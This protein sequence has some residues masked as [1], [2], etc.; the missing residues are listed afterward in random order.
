LYLWFEVGA[1]DEPD[2]LAGVA[3]FLEHMLFKG[4]A[5]RG[6]GEAAAT[7]EGRG[8]DLNAW[9]SWDE[10]CFHAVVDAE[11][12]EDA[13]DVLI[14]MTSASTLD[15][16]ELARER[17]VVVDEIAGY[18]SDPEAFAADTCQAVLFPGHAYG[19]PVLGTPETVRALDRPRVEA[20]WRAHYHPGRAIL[21]VSGPV[22]V[23]AVREAVQ[24]RIRHWPRGAQRAALHTP[25]GPARGALTRVKKP[26]GAGAVHMGYRTPG[27]DHPA[28]PALDVLSACLG[29]GNAAIL[30]SALE[31]EDG[32]ATASWA[33]LSSYRGAGALE[34]GF[35][36][37][38]TAE[39]LRRA[40]AEL[41]AVARLGV[42][43]EQVLRARE[44]VLCDMLFA[45]ETVD[46]RAADL[47]WYVAR[48]GSPEAAK[49]YRDRVA[50]VDAAA[51][52]AVAA[53]W[54]SPEHRRVVVIDRDVDDGALQRAVRSK[55]PPRARSSAKAWFQESVHGVRVVVL[56]DEGEL[57]AIRV[58]GVGG[59]LLEGPRTAGLSR[60]W[61]TALTRGA[62]ARDAQAFAER[63]DTLA[64]VL[65]GVAGRS[66]MGVAASLPA[67]RVNAAIELVGDVLVD[68]HFDPVDVEHTVDEL[69]DDLPG[70][71]D[72]PAQ[73]AGEALWRALFPEHPWR[74]SPGG[75]KSSLERL[76]PTS[77]R[78][79]HGAVTGRANLTVAIAGGVNVE[80]VLASVE[81]WA[82]E[83]DSGAAPPIERP[84]APPR[85][86]VPE[87]RAG[88][89]QAA[90]LL[91]MRGVDHDHPDRV[92]LHI[93]AALLDSQ[94]GRLFMSLRER[95]ALAY[96]VWASSDNG[97]VGGV[98]SVGITTDPARVD[99]AAAGLRRELLQLA[100]GGPTDDEL[101]RVKRMLGGGMALRRERVSARASDLAHAAHFKRPYELAV[102]RAELDAIRP[103]DVS[104]ALQRLRPDLG[105]IAVAR[106]GSPTEE[107]TPT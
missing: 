84:A 22:D 93:A 86:R 100:E 38:D 47:S 51:V 11:A 14:D 21:A 20:F 35:Q 4:T 18:A 96:S 58:V 105:L 53:Q 106:P 76:N 29:Q 26:F 83:L 102:L 81:T 50:A 72:R 2:E 55:P 19:R 88:H 12:W 43:G 62:G 65:E 34:L 33:T 71:I 98:F 95:E 46:G 92:A 79:F 74:L 49:H 59:Q 5:R 52:R 56:P 77:L 104:G 17:E 8:G 40:I 6:L 94:S 82:E 90:V 23:D 69:I 30:P 87:S 31:I 60:A 101:A 44:G 78:S 70:A 80:R 85:G 67:D 15:A 45:R 73:V 66:T 64:L 42:D 32:V 24:R 39:A 57:A 7:I 107:P 13:L 16:D 97:L 28:V 61:S 3:H 91:G 37:G 10:T 41:D 54:L 48:H 68:P 89:E 9:T 36:V 103:T 27:L 99:A 63:T 25:V 1:V 75:T